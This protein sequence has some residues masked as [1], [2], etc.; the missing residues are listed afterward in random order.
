MRCTLQNYEYLRP[1][2]KS[3]EDIRKLDALL[4]CGSVIGA[5]GKYGISDRVFRRSI[6]KLKSDAA[7]SGVSPDHDM[8]H[9]APDGYLVKGTSTLYGDDGQVKQQWVKTQVDVT[10][11][12]EILRE[13][14]EATLQEYKGAGGVIKAPKVEAKNMMHLIPIGDPHIGLYSW[15]KETGEDFDTTIACRD[16]M[17]GIQMVLDGVPSC[18]ECLVVNLGD[19][20]H[21]DNSENRT[22]RSGHALDVDSRYSRV[23]DLGNRLMLS[24]VDAARRKHKKV[25][26]ISLPGNHDDHSGIMLSSLL[27][28][29]YEKDKRVEVC[30][31]ANIVR[32]HQFGKNLLGFTHGHSIKPSALGEIMAHDCP[33]QWG[34]TNYRY[35]HTGHIHSNNSSDGRGWRWESHRTL[36]AQD[37]WSSG[38]GY[39]SGRDIKGILYHNEFGEVNRSTVDIRAIRASL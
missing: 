26:V 4:Q 13:S 33:E 23:V 17:R 8:T 31:S 35:W 6:A 14:I 29:Y 20:F 5:A 38:A 30:K 3:P 19:Y 25:R 39:R 7:L 27:D 1:Y 12:I 16:L 9:A 22:T 21:A 15:H 24:V 28:I 10:R 11:R 18:S 32:Y 37:A 2:A 34:N 36:A